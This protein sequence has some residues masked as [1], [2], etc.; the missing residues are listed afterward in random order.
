MSEGGRI[1]VCATLDGAEE[2]STTVHELAHELL[3]RGR[4]GKSRTVR[5]CEAEAVAFAVCHAV[6]LNV[7]TASSDYIGMYDGTAATLTESLC[8]IRDTAA[9]ILAGLLPAEVV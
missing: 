8:A 5:E 1:T 3:H 7:G 2:F 4:T 9:R 6:G